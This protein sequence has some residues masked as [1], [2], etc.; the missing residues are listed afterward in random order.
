MANPQ[1]DATQRAQDAQNPAPSAM[2]VR[3]ACFLPK[4]NF[5]NFR[6]QITDLPDVFFAKAEQ[7]LVC[8]A[9]QISHKLDLDLAECVMM[10]PHVYGYNSTHDDGKKAMQRDHRL[11]EHTVVVWDE[12]FA[13]KYAGELLVFGLSVDVHSVSPKQTKKN[14]R[15]PDKMRYNIRLTLVAPQQVSSEPE[16]DADCN[17]LIIDYPKDD[18]QYVAEQAMNNW[19]T[20]C[21]NAE[22]DAAGRRLP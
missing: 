1:S 19:N 16:R 13:Q 15:K 17:L 11:F 6:E 3:R 10:R 5:M 20:W 9:L 18:V 7:R 2:P 4:I 14:T 22:P 12:H 8:D 21:M